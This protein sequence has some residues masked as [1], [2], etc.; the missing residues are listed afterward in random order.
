MINKSLKYFVIKYYKWRAII[1]DQTKRDTRTITEPQR[2]SRLAV[3]KKFVS[4]SKIIT[5][6][7]VEALANT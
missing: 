7:L 1:K 6:E 4:D 2:I 5:E 3:K